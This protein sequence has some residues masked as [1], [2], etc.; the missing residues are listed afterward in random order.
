LARTSEQSQNEAAMAFTRILGF[1]CL[2]AFAC[3]EKV[4]SLESTDTSKAGIHP[5]SGHLHV[6]S[7][8]RHKVTLPK[9]FNAKK[10]AL[11][12]VEA[13][14]KMPK[15]TKLLLSARNRHH[16]KQQESGTWKKLQDQRFHEREHEEA[17]KKQ[18]LEEQKLMEDDLKK[19]EKKHE[20][21]R[22][23]HE[24]QRK[25]KRRW[26]AKLVA[27]QKEKRK[28]MHQKPQQPTDHSE[29]TQPVTA[30][31]PQHMQPPKH[32]EHKH[33]SKHFQ[34][35]QPSK[36]QSSL[37]RAGKSHN[38]RRH[39]HHTALLQTDENK[40]VVAALHSAYAEASSLL[41]TPPAASHMVAGDKQEKSTKKHNGGQMPVR[42]HV[43][44]DKVRSILKELSPECSE[45]FEN[46]ME[47]KGRAKKLH[48]FGTSLY[49]ATDE[50][51]S[52]LGGAVCENHAT[53]RQTQ[54]AADSRRLVVDS[55]V[56]G[57]S[58]L[59]RK[60]IQASDIKTLATFV[61]GVAVKAVGPASQGQKPSQVM[62][63]VDCSES[64]GGK[65][66]AQSQWSK[67]EAG[68][69]DPE[70]MHRVHSAAQRHGLAVIFVLATTCLVL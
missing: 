60:C 65:Y 7:H 48:L 58:C 19:Q 24:K 27:A 15:L 26:E 16:Q 31:H 57:K 30:T 20:K 62:L 55:K 23:L 50:S 28:A 56:D 66:A 39:A 47:G 4:N 35:V 52:D 41:A 1:A 54:V 63:S 36:H 33:P 42:E 2:L 38:F 10:L 44:L 9:L 67:E 51:C 32:E 21:Q 5:S 8:G 69:G 40:T 49:G 46:M 29:K 11:K 64:G 3:A 17:R 70:P 68:A 6:L 22:K 34:H 12:K 25:I 59:P 45:Q 53:I 13:S 43:P 18:K 14:K 61:Q 37:A